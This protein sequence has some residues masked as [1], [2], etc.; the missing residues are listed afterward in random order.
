MARVKSGEV[1][2]STSRLIRRLRAFLILAV[3][4]AV[5]ASVGLVASL[6]VKSPGQRAAEQA[7]PSGSL[8]TASMQEKVLE[9]TV[10]LRGTVGASAEIKVTGASTSTSQARR[11]VTS[12]AVSRGAEVA[13]GTLLGTVSG[14]PILILEGDSP[15]YRD[16]V[17]G[18]SGDDV[19]E[20]QASLIK[21][22]L[23]PEKGKS[24][25]YDRATEAAVTKLYQSKSLQPLSTSTIDV[26]ETTRIQGAEETNRTSQRAVED[27]RL[28]LKAVPAGEDRT[29]AQRALTRAREDAAAAQ[30][31]LAQIKGSAGVIFPLSE[32]VFSPMPAI[33][34]SIQASVGTDLS[35]ATD[36]TV[37]TLAG[38]SMTV[39][40][41]VP[42]GS[43]T[44]ITAGMP[45]TVTDDQSGSIKP[46]TVSALGAYQAAKEANGLA[47]AAATPGYPLT[48]AIPE[49]L[50][51]DWIGRNVAV[52]IAISATSA[53]VLVAP[54]ASIRTHDDGVSYVVVV[55]G[56]TQ[57]E[58]AVRAGLVAGGEVEVEPVQ[59]DALNGKSLV[60]LG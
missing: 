48:L 5:L 43:Q 29:A 42:P 12:I 23:L 22:G 20:L 47:A 60:K 34:E 55:D 19:G 58:V 8:L 49:A 51:P 44:G 7:A 37:L 33:V 39:G 54:L 30:K 36:S 13:S 26:S 6:W 27:A 24:G 31:A 53:K 11:V 32:L 4:A 56:T 2:S 28:A 15:V 50:A 25:T 38:G 1:E 59:A 21:L 16:F 40:A 9:K 41:L 18:V 14:R 52:K 57:S 35:S 10:I 46:A 45:A 3:T 17:P